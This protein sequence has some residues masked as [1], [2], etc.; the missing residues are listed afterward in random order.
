MTLILEIQ[1]PKQKKPEID[2]NQL[3][4]SYLKSQYAQLKQK[5]SKNQDAVQKVK[6]V[7]ED[8][9][10]LRNSTSA[11]ALVNATVSSA[12]LSPKLAE[13]N[14]NQKRGNSALRSA[15]WK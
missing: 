7:K 13:T 12:L 8:K 3:E 14:E 5:N 11:K 2:E 4:T 9:L 15:I 6:V 10:K 1:R